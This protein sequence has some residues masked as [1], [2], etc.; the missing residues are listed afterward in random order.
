ME[1]EY[2]APR[3]LW[4]KVE[5]DDGRGGYE[6]WCHLCGRHAVGEIDGRPVCETH[7]SA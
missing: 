7:A 5:H 1:R 4:G 3:E 6:A 2:V